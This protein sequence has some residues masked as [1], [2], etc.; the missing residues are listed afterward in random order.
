M[1][2]NKTNSMNKVKTNSII[3]KYIKSLTM[4]ETKKKVDHMSIFI[5]S[6]NKK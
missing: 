2:K 6:K 3:Y 4:P 1:Y 5:K